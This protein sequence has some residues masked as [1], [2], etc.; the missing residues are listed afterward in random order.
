[1]EKPESIMETFRK[2]KADHPD[3]LM[4]FRMGDFYESFNEDADIV[5]RVL[6]ITLTKL[7]ANRVAGVVYHELDSSLKKLIKAG[8]KVGVLERK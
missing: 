6:R 1:M 3:T 4:L 7:G 5:A 8:H 2:F